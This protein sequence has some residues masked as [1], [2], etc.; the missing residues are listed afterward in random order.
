MLF[1]FGLNTIFLRTWYVRRAVRRIGFPKEGVFDFLDAGSGFGQYSTY[2]FK[3]FPG[4]RILGL[5]RDPDFVD[6]G[7][8]YCERAGWDRLRFE[9]MD[10]LNMEYEDVFDLIL[11]VDVMEHIKEDVNLLSRFSKSLKRS[12]RLILTTPTVYRKHDDDGAF[13]EEHAR[14]GYSEE[15][16]RQKLS[17]ANLHVESLNYGYGVFGDL[18]WRLGIRNVMKLFSGLRFL[19]ILVF[20]YFILAF[21]LVLVLMCLDYVWPN[22]RG[23]GM[24][25]TACRP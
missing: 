11:C 23:T 13:V 22:R 2:L 1:F 3:R 21:P 6:A 25:V 14:P 15:E 24:V 17:A 18:S 10:L 9:T 4:A 19:K 8:V 12:G 20:F 5:E 7:N 16:M